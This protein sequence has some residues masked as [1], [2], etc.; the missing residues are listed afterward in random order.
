MNSI[1]SLQMALCHELCKANLGLQFKN[2]ILFKR[3]D[4][5]PVLLHQGGVGYGV[6]FWSGSLPSRCGILN[7]LIV[8]LSAISDVLRYLRPDQLLVDLLE[9][10]LDGCLLT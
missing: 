4:P 5:A 8:K 7:N 3:K 10:D 6:N 9:M 2:F 1:G